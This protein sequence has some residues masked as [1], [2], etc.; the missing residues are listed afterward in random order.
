VTAARLVAV[1]L[2]ASVPQH[3]I[4]ADVAARAAQVV[5]Q[6]LTQNRHEARS[7]HPHVFVDCTVVA[8]SSSRL[9]T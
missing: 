5:Y 7:G 2:K 4:R 6:P 3:M 8:K 9:I 1:S